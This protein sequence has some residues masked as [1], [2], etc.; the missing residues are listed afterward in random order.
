MAGISSLIN[1]L[2]LLKQIPIFEKLNW[3]ELQKIARKSIIREFKKGDTVCLEGTPPDYFYCLISGRLQAY[4]T[5]PDGKK[6][7]VD[8]IHKGMHFGIISVL[9]GENHSMTFDAINDSVVLTIDKDD[10]QAILKAVPHLGIELSQHLSRRIRRKVQGAKS[11]FE[12]T[13]IS[14]YSPAKGSG[15]STYAANLAL[16]LHKETGKKVVYVNIFSRQSSVDKSVSAPDAAAPSWKKPAIELNQIAGDHEKISAAIIRDDLT[17]DLLNAVFDSADGM[18]K[19]VIGSFVSALVGDYHYVIVDLPNEM[20]DVVLEALTQSDRV[21]LITTERKK[22]LELIRRVVDR[23]E[24]ALKENFRE[25]RVRVI[26]RAL[27]DKIYLSFEEINQ[28]IQYHVYSALPVIP[29]SDL[30]DKVEGS[31]LYFMRGH[32]RCEY[33]Q[34]V[35]RIARQIGGVSVGLVLGGGAALGLAHIGVL[36]VLEQ[37]DIPIDIIV[38]SSMGALI[39]SLWASGKNADGLEEVAREFTHPLSKFKLLDPPLVPISGLVRGRA[40]KHWLRRHLGSRTFYNVRVP[41]KVVAYD[42]IRREEIVIDSGSLVEA[43]RK[44][45]AIPGVIKPIQEGQ[46]MVI[47]GGVLNPLPTNVLA[48]RGIKKIIAVNVLQSP[49]DVAEGF[50]IIQHQLQKERAVPFFKSPFHYIKFRLGQALYKPFNPNISDII[51]QTL[52]ASEYVI[53]EQS[54]QLADV[55]IHPDLVGIKWHQ[56]DRV[57]DLIQRGEEATRN[58]MPEIKRLVEE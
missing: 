38:G 1:R 12:S 39:G 48:S 50:D 56:L 35:T 16:S 11:V 9:T 21:H 55:V 41:F 4:T 8:F 23:L 42:L 17:I 26:I 19:N 13:V 52:Q 34:A 15:S 40:I 45:V 25:E 44:S 54:G 3:F 46:K 43:V 18:L 47:D 30:T 53:A 37:E 49:D 36:R 33:A 51:I 29:H 6:G 2:N 14:I 20:D 58:R 27:H 57:D 22:D 7:N 31:S 32:A 5:S 24:A 28:V 10:F